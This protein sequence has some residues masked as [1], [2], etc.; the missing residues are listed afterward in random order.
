M[1][2]NLS[3]S[4]FLDYSTHH[5]FPLGRYL[6]AAKAARVS[7]FSAENDATSPKGNYDACYG[8]QFTM[9]FD[10]LGLTVW[11]VFVVRMAR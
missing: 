11:A 4:L 7:A 2:L 9:T 8:L 5:N 6:G 10:T 3:Y 1:I